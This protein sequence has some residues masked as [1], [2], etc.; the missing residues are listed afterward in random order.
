[1]ENSNGGK[2]WVESE[3]LGL[4]G[5]KIRGIFLGKLPEILKN[6]VGKILGGK[7]SPKSHTWVHSSMTFSLS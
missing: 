4:E 1:M 7:F 3:I 5:K 6:W 2:F